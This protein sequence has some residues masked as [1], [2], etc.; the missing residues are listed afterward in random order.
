MWKLLE[1]FSLYYYLIVNLVFSTAVFGVGLSF[2]LP[3]FLIIAYFDLSLTF[4][5]TFEEKNILW[6]ITF[7]D[8][9][10]RI[11]FD[12]VNAHEYFDVNPSGGLEVKTPVSGDRFKP[13]QYDV[14]WSTES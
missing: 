13:T 10:N 3:H 14:S 2:C 9:W 8:P 1:S 6:I 7:Q 5:Y 4:L 12:L 11:T